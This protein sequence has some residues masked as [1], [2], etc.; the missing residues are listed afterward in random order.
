MIV[1][2]AV[3]VTVCSI[4]ASTITS[5]SAAVT[6]RRSIRGPIFAAAANC[7]GEG[8]TMSTDTGPPSTFPSTGSKHS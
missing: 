6:H 8:G 2:I 7:T 3:L 4:E 5:I 1:G